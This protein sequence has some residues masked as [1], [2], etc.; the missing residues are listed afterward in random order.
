MQ[1][2]WHTIFFRS[3]LQQSLRKRNLTAKLLRNLLIISHPYFDQVKN[4][5][6]LVLF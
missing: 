5:S 3:N 2:K 4:R 1:P 6:N